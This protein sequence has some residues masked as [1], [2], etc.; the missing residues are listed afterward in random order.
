MH[1]VLVIVKEDG[2]EV[3]FGKLCTLIV[4]LPFVLT[5]KPPHSISLV[6]SILR[7]DGWLP[8]E[9]VMVMVA[10]PRISATLMTLTRAPK[11]PA[12]AG[13]K[14]CQLLSHANFLICDLRRLFS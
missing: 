12:S 9:V 11:G 14:L 13:C 1:F 8:D 2:Q 6:F 5:P 3:S 7:C 4:S 10:C